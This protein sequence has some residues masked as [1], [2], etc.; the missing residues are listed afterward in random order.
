MKKNIFIVCVFVALIMVSK[1]AAADSV[2]NFCAV[3]GFNDKEACVVSPQIKAFG[4]DQIA[5]VPDNWAKGLKPATSM[6]VCN[7]RH[8]AGEEVGGIRHGGCMMPVSMT[9]LTVGADKKIKHLKDKET[10]QKIFAPIEDADEAISYASVLEKAAPMYEFPK[11][12]YQFLKDASKKGKWLDKKLK[13]TH[14]E[15]MEDGW[16]VWLFYEP[17]CGCHKMELFEEEYVIGPEG[18]IKKLKS[19]AVWRSEAE[20]CVD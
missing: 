11:D 4:C 7:T 19:R 5:S 16:H 17:M 14:A 20:I 1:S 2:T 18:D 13:P 10:F 12:Y 3:L 15:K 8:K 6:V 9:I